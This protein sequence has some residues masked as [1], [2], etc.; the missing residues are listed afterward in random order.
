MNGNYLEV[1]ISSPY[2][3]PSP[4]VGEGW[5]EGVVT[6]GLTLKYTEH[7]YNANVLPLINYNSVPT[8]PLPNPLPQGERGLNSDKV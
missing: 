1:F 5:G 2:S 8:P 4:L 3:A 6:I 7:T